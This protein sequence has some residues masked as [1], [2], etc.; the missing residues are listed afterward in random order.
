M[1][2]GD[3]M[4]STDVNWTPQ[5]TEIAVKAY[6]DLLD[7]ESQGKIISRQSV[8]DRL[9]AERLTRRTSRAVEYRFQNIEAVMAEENLR[10]LGMAPRYHSSRLTRAAV[11][12]AVVG[13]KLVQA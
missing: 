3:Y 11:L 10:G 12:A 4:R 7:Q 1:G 6:F 8:Y 13:C 9:A 5:E 2:Y